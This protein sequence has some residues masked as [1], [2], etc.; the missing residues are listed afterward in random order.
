MERGKGTGD[1]P[2]SQRGRRENEKAA[3]R[4]DLGRLEWGDR[5]GLR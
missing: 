5:M 4:N 1:T 2:G 3:R